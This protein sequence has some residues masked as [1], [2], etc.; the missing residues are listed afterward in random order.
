MR[1]NIF[2]VP[3]SSKR[4]A[5]LPWDEFQPALKAK[6]NHLTSKGWG[7]LE[8]TVVPVGQHGKSF[9]AVIVAGRPGDPPLITPDRR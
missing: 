2:R 6:L 7:H 5:S 4:R 8:T 3:S 9:S 1:F